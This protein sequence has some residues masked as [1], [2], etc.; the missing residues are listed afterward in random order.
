[1]HNRIFMLQL[2]II[3]PPPKGV[4]GTKYPE[5]VEARVGRL[6][7]FDPVVLWIYPES[8]ASSHVWLCALISNAKTHFCLA[9]LGMKRHIV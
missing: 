9:K 2:P 7:S 8:M 3:D 4:G 5:L 1:V 6:L